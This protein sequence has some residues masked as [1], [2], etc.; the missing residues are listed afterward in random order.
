MELELIVES[1]ET[2]GTEKKR[3]PLAGRLTLGRGPESP[4]ALEGTGLSREHLAFES[5]AGGVEVVDLSS[6]GTWLNGRRLQPGKRYP[7]SGA[8]RIEIP[9]YAIRCSVPERSPAQG[10]SPSAPSEPGSLRARIPS[11]TPLELWTACFVLMALAV[12][13]IFFQ[14]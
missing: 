14:L 6:N 1:K 2:G 12:L 5:G 13:A 7:A 10:A 11:I 9:G 8:D 3:L 4:F